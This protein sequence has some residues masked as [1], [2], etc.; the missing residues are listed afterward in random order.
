LWRLE[1]PFTRPSPSV[2]ELVA[3]NDWWSWWRV[4]NLRT[5]P[6]WARVRLAPLVTAAIALVMAATVTLPAPAEASTSHAY[7][8]MP[9]FL[10]MGRSGVYSEMYVAQLYFKTTGLGANTSR[11]VRVV[12]ELPAAGTQIQ[13]FSTVILHVTSVAPP[14]PVTRTVVKKPVVKKTVVKKT[15]V[16]K[17]VVKK[18]VGTRHVVKKPVIK[19]LSVT[20]KDIKTPTH[21]KR[22]A[23]KHAVEDFRVGVATW[24]SY[25]PGQCATWYLPRGTRINVENIKT[26][27]VISCVAT[28]REGARGNRVVDL[29]ETQFAELA[30]LGVGVLPVR[31]TW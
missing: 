20:R 21:K 5:Q 17:P 22:R 19:V 30:P 24:Y 27:K 1:L 3:E 15:V 25:T 14:A 26:G 4:E 16:K 29:S 6:R 11:W 31:V 28:D 12:G 8:A 2:E 7:E 10:G 23:G 18:P 9:N 13:R